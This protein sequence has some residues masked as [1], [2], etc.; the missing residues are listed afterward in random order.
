MKLLLAA[1]AVLLA[2][3]PGA[4]ARSDPPLRLL[5]LDH[6]VI[7]PNGNG[8]NDTVTLH[9]SAP[10]GTLLGLRVYVWGG[11]LV[12]WVRIRTGVTVP[13]PDVTWNGT[14][15]DGNALH[16]GSFVV[17]ACYED[18]GVLLPPQGVPRPGIAEASV[19]R[20]PW[21][22]TGCLAN[23]RVIRVERLAAY[24]D[25]PRSFSPGDRIPLVASADGG[26]ATVEL[27]HDCTGTETAGTVI[28]R[29]AA[30]G[31]YHADVT[32]PW[33]DHFEAPV[34]VRD[35]RPLDDP[36][37]HTA[38]VVWP[39]LTWRAYSSYDADLNGIPDS[40]YQFW[41]QRRVSFIGPLLRNGVEDD[42]EAAAAFPRWVCSRSLRTQNVTDVE[43]G[44]IPPKELS[45]YAA[46]VYPGHSEYYQRSTYDLLKRYRDGG[47]HL[48]ILQANPFYR[49]VRIDRK[50]NAEV[51]LDY[52]AREGRSDFGLAGVGYDGCCFPKVRAAPYVAAG[53]R[54]YQRV[55]W[56][57]R[58][59][60]I[61]PG[62]DFGIAYSESDRVDPGLSPP[63]HVIAA[64]AIMRGKFGVIH[65]AMTW[66]RAGKGQVFA[67]GSY[68]FL[69]MGKH[70]TYKLLDNVWRKLV[71]PVS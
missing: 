17:T 49:P 19:R 40:W 9:T 32:D 60:G 11:R 12:G 18:A 20:P 43:L 68:T 50:R 37:P 8:I 51:L 2:A 27:E 46:V 41:R 38:L 63:D 61:G 4:A 58:G 5:S 54:D 59:T 33:G 31:L 53:G 16:D 42:A 24:V 64:Q 44:R 56:L 52:D 1:A 65:A 10:A 67:T 39:Y 70:L 29:E 55:K 13:G 47:G 30:P 23:A 57:F 21:R 3:V 28:P 6:P 22:R 7:S 14:R 34:V 15:A 48:I 26:Q 25:K 36:L 45:R 62:Q 69:R 66:T 35:R 71:G